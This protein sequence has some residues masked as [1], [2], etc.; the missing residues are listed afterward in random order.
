MNTLTPTQI[1]LLKKNK[2][3]IKVIALA[4]VN[5]D[6]SSEVETL[7]KDFDSFAAQ[8]EPEW[9]ILNWSG[10]YADEIFKVQYKSETLTVGDLT[11]RGV[12]DRFIVS[13]YGKHL[14]VDTGWTHNYNISEVK[15]IERKVSAFTEE[16]MIGFAEWVRMNWL[17]DLQGKFYKKSEWEFRYDYKQLLTLY[18][19]E[20]DSKLIEVIQISENKFK[21]KTE[22]QTQ[23]KQLEK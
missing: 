1:E 4:F 19:Q 23:L 9:K 5:Y 7:A 20:Q 2:E 3:D 16:D 17:F 21:I 14:L 10:R 8:F 15:K 12:I 18:L 6:V 11:D 22:L 13:S